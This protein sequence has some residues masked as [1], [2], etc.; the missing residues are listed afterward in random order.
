VLG[1]LHQ[2]VAPGTS[3]IFLSMIVITKWWD[4]GAVMYL[5]QGADFH[6][7]S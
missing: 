7:A 1:P 2:N 3:A 4:A 5:G 6:M